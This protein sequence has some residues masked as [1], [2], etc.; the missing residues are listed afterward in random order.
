MAWIKKYR[1]PAAGTQEYVCQCP[2]C[3][4]IETL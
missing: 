3:L 4:T 2:R 1:L